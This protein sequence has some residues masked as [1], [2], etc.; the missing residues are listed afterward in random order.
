VNGSGPAD[1]PPTGWKAYKWRAFVAIGLAFV[2]IVF[3]S[4]M[5]FVL[6]SAI[7]DDFG[8]TLR[9][10][11]WVVI[12]DSLIV[13]ALLL[14]MGGLADVVGRR[15]IYVLGLAVYGVGSV[16]TGLAPTFA[17]LIVARVVAALG[18][19]LVQSVMTGMLVA[20]FPPEERGRAMGAQTTAVSVGAAVGPLLGGLA[21]QV[22]PWETLFFLVAAPVAVSIVAAIAILDDDRKELSEAPRAFDPIG[23]LLSAVAVLVLVVTIS[24]PLAFDWL[25]VP[26][27]AGGLLV[28]GLLTGFVRWELARREPM[29]ELR[30]FALGVFRNAVSIRFLGFIGATTTSLLL[31][32]YLV[33]FRGITEGLAGTIIFLVAAGMGISAQ[34]SGNVS[35][36]YGPRPPTIVGLVVQ[37]A[38][39]A[40]LVVAGRDAPIGLL[41]PVVFLA[42]VGM[43]LW[44]VANNTAMMASVPPRN[45]AVIGAFT[46]VTRTLGTVVGQAVATAVVVAVM[47]SD[48]FDIPLSEIADTPG[49]GS[50][51]LAGW[52]AAYGVVIVVS[53]AA[54][55]LALLLPSRP[56]R[57]EDPVAGVAP[58]PADEVPAPTGAT[59]R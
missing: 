49:A 55:P 45:L 13:S 4:T 29:L 30:L 54:L 3:A 6:L 27:F 53:L 47:A 46:N 15:R 33:S 39:A 7:A 41:V 10:V 38:V 42:G 25:S 32:V 43:S 8:V 28:V 26:T 31:P 20:A 35:D 40:V 48:G 14:P 16:M 24:N 9:A 23:G 19:A 59:P 18:N 57:P 11:G 56:V 37:I 1:R 50:A 52:Q 2:T 44:N 36:R 58:A 12:V 51:F 34:I 17:V 21:L 5:V 22:M